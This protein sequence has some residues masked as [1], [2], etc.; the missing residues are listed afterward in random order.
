MT[1]RSALV[2]LTLAAVAACGDDT[3]N[4]G[5][6][7]A[8]SGATTTTTT[9]TTTSSTG[10]TSSSTGLGGDG[11]GG[12]TSAGGGGAGEGGV[13]G[14]GGAGGGQ[15]C[16]PSR[17][18]LPLLAQPPDLLS[19]TGLYAALPDLAIADGITP[20]RPQFELWSDGAVKSRWVHLP[21]CSTIDTTDMDHWQL[22]VGTRLYKEFVSGGVRVETRVMH[23]FKADGPAA[24]VP[25]WWFATYVWNA[26]GT[27]AV[28]DVDGEVDALETTHDVPAESTCFTCHGYLA[29]R[30]LG[31]SAVQLG[32]DEAGAGLDLDALEAAGLLSTPAPEVTVPGDPVAQAALGVLHANCG[33]C[34]NDTGVFFLDPF[35]L[36][37]LVDDATV[38]DTGAGTTAVGVETTSFSA[39]GFRIAPGDTADSCV[40]VRMA[41]RG[42]GSQQMPPFA[43]EVVDGDGLAA[44]NAWIMALTDADL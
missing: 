32:H 44:V 11:S 42:P 14:T 7:G 6:G 24:E 9:T 10:D 34:H 26:E 31:F 29:E 18:P 38:G 39:T 8:G 23:R 12:A 2:F 4:P 21:E 19:E 28:R 22:P 20:Y 3:S 15:A 17:E 43:T 25:D 36:R 37:L 40:S 30:A 41:A 13:G 16:S 5:A 1:S 35:H 27:E 33:H